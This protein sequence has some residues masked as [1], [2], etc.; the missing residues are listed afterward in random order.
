M[1]PSFANQTLT[2]VR[3]ARRTD[4]YGNEQVLDWSEDA[5]TL[6]PVTGCSVQPVD[7]SEALSAGRDEVVGQ[8]WAFMPAGTDVDALDRVR[9]PEGGRDFEVVGEVQRMP[10]ATGGLDHVY[11]LL[12]RV[13]G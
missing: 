11:A 9:L 6:T 10:S 4:R 8:R 3:A 13:E 12:K 1:L 5:V 7:S 2:V